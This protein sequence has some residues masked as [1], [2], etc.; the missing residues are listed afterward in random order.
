MFQQLTIPIFQKPECLET[1]IE[2]FDKISESSQTEDVPSIIRKI[3]EDRECVIVLSISGGKDSQ[4]AQAFILHLRTY[5][6]TLY[7]VVGSFSPLSEEDKQLCYSRVKVEIECQVSFTKLDY[8]QYLLSSQM[9][10]TLTNL[11]EH[12]QVFSHDT[13]N[14]YLRGEKLTPRLLWDNVEHLIQVDEDGSIIFDDSVIDKNFSNC[15]ELVRRQYSG[16]EHRVIRGIG[17]ISCVYVNV[18]TGQ[19][20]VIDYRVYDPDGDGKTKLDHVADMLRNLVYSKQL[21]FARVLMD[22]W[23]AA[24]KLM[25]LIEQLGKIYYCPLKRNRL[26]DDSGGV[27]KYKQ[28][29]Q[30]SWSTQERQQGKLIK[31]KNFPSDKKVKLF[32]VTVFT[33]RTDHIVTNDLSQNS[34]DEVQEANAVRWKVEEF[35]RGVKQLTGIEACQCRKARIQRNHIACA[36]LAW[37]H[38]KRLAALTAQTIYQL[39]YQWLS[40][41]LIEELKHP[42][43]SM[44]LI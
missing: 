40:D 16:T 11:A 38:L 30:L 19:F 33:D 10:Y 34:T 3:I 12:L 23:Y 2:W 24:Q 7:I 6:D 1:E 4:A 5:A 41:C 36:I 32:R 27:E 44:R 22:S 29:E 28:I 18:N 9:N 43:I 37:T 15:I 31:I 21:P 42:S 17:L 20:W 39:K 14:R 13:I 25:A 26:V 8:C 35:H